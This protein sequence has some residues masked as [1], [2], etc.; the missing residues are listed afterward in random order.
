MSPKKGGTVLVVDDEK[1]VR[2]VC[3]SMLEY[4]GYEVVTAGDGQTAL[5]LFS[6]EPDRYDCVL[7]DLVMPR[8]SGDEC[9]KRMRKIRGD[10]AVVLSSGYDENEASM[11]YG[12]EAHIAFLKKPYMISNLAEKL[13]HII[14]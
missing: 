8:M 5:E 7:L 14:K 11:S 13:N 9:L 2:D 6:A 1:S 12:V 4:L 3:G 10:V